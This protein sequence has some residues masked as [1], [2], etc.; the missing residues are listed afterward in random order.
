MGSTD[1]TQAGAV[2]HAINLS[3]HPHT[4]AN[5]SMDKIQSM[6]RQYIKY[7]ACSQTHIST[8]RM[9]YLV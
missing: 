9:F 8:S 4:S 3:Q 1:V 2:C 5:T 6:L 7:L